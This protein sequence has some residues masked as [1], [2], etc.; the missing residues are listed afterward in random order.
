MADVADQTAR[1]ERVAQ[2]DAEVEANLRRNMIANFA[3]GM[4][5]MTGFR[6]IYAPTLIP[7]YL[8][9]ISGSAVIVGLGQALLQLGLLSTPLASAAALEHRKRILPAAMRYGSAMRGAVLGLA[10]SG[11]FLGGWWLVA[12][13]L[14]FLMLLGLFNGMQR[15]AFQMVIAKL[16]PADRRGRLQGWRNLAGGI[17][18]AIL[19]FAAGKWLI[20]ANALGNGYATTFL[21]AFLLTSLGLVAL[22]LWA[23]ESDAPVV[24]EQVGLRQRVRDIPALL[25]DRD[26]RWFMAAQL[27]A[28]AG[29][30]A[31]P[32]YIL[33]ATGEGN[34][35]EGAGALSLDGA[36][37]GLLSLAFLGADTLS[38]PLWGSIGDRNGYRGTIIA[39]LGFTLAG[40]ALLASASAPWMGVAAF[41]A[42]GIGGAGFSLSTQTMVLEFGE[43]EDLPMR[44]ALSTMVEGG[45][46]ALTPLIGGALLLW[47]GSGVLLATAAVLTSAAALLM[48]AKVRD[49]RTLRRI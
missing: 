35:G 2:F 11:Y 21:F 45:V 38:N 40:V 49:P 42:F 37:I 1:S 23:R 10:L 14:L 19:S 8:H 29:R 3:H 30:I 15:V 36:T 44:I 17:V 7:A 25:A 48:L 13:T 31:A 18:A 5:G 47:A 34:G 22:G 27:L 4:L 12:A 6:I 43:R 33:I 46:A 28:M 41:A 16:I 39:S 26:Y 20:D 9:L 24:R 32:F